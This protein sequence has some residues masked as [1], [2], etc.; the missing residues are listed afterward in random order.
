MFFLK[1][2]LI[3]ILAAIAHSLNCRNHLPCDFCLQLTGEMFLE[4]PAFYHYFK[5]ITHIQGGKNPTTKPI[6]FYAVAFL[7][8]RL[9]FVY[10]SVSQVG[11]RDLEG[12]ADAAKVVL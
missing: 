11:S 8:Q 5:N 9:P 1:L 10:A 3:S 2:F 6:I 7:S 4:I 12:L